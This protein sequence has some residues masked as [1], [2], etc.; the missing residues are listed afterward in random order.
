MVI[1]ITG[2]KGFSLEEQEAIAYIEEVLKKQERLEQLQQTAR[3]TGD[4]LEKAQRT[5]EL[6][7]LRIAEESEQ[8]VDRQRQQLQKKLEKEVEAAKY[9]LAHMVR[10]KKR[11]KEK[12]VKRHISDMTR[13]HENEIRKTR[14]QIRELLR[15]KRVSP[16][17]GKRLWFSLFMPRH[18]TEYLLVVLM[19]MFGAV[20]VPALIYQ[21]IPD[22]GIWQ[23]FILLPVFV[24]II[25]ACYIEIGKR[26]TRRFP[27]LFQECRSKVDYMD[28]LKKN[29]R[30]TQDSIVKADDESRYGLKSLDEEIFRQQQELR[31]LRKK[32]TAQLKSFEED[33]RPKIIEEFQKKSQT[34]LDELTQTMNGLA[35]ERS[36]TME[37]ISEL[38]LDILDHYE[39]TLTSQNLNTRNLN[40]ILSCLKE[41]KAST[42][43]E[44]LERV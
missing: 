16:I 19:W 13:D 41:G 25:S 39:E 43:E 26:T 21:L 31:D 40:R 12:K 3:E 5:L 4:S 29:I 8:M 38:Q 33:M 32:Q 17:C 11:E 14:K 10:K 22:H 36:L 2:K 23:F 24:V 44:A 15:E 9:H 20:A 6:Y 28:E 7:Q 42:L 1:I 35:K 30:H 18:I 37:M 27:E 34:R